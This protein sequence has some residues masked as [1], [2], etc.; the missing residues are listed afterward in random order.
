MNDLTE[1]AEL[2]ARC[3]H[4]LLDFDGPVC[5]VFGGTTDRAVAD[6]LR[7][8][9]PGL[10]AE[11]TASSDPFDVLRHAATLGPAVLDTVAREFTRLEVHAVATAT[12]TPGAEEAIAALHA[13]GHTITIVSNNSTAAVEA[14]LRSHDLMPSLDGISARTCP[15]PDLLKPSPHLLDQ[16]IRQLDTTA[17]RCV[18]VGDSTTDV[19]A[20]RAAGA[21]AIAY[22]NKPGK[23]ERLGL[24]GPD[25]TIDTMSAFA[26]AARGAQRMHRLA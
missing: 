7:A 15:D 2:L 21:A 4:V 11:V 24:I 8:D 16:A 20:A 10:P 6:Q 17:S 19:A 14:Y 23:R 1:L 26:R 9:L 12:P 3:P 5:A 22:A 18:L 25:A 13:T